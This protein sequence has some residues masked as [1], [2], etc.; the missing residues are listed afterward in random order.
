MKLK[1][2]NETECEEPE[3]ELYLEKVCDGV[4]LVGK[5][6]DLKLG[7]ISINETGTF[8]LGALVDRF[9][10]FKKAGFQFGERGAILREGFF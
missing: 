8:S 4:V 2:R 6:N 9:E 3:V 10:D 7:L 5:I 1:I